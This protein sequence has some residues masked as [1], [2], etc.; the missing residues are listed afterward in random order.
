MSKIDYK[1]L[2]YKDE[3]LGVED[4]FIPFVP[5]QPKPTPRWLA[6][7]LLYVFPVKTTKEFSHDASSC[8][9]DGY[10]RGNTRQ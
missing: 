7:E 4:E 6:V 8:G 5:P 3:G 10:L 9:A 1:A 2:L